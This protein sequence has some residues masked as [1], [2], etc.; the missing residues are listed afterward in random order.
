MIII[1]V[2]TEMTRLSKQISYILRHDPASVNISLDA[3]GS[4]TV[5]K[6][7]EA[8]N[9][10]VEDIETIARNDDKGRFVIFDGKIKAAQGHSFHVEHNMKEVLNPGYVFHGTSREAFMKIM[11][12]EKIEARSRTFVHLSKEKETA[13]KVALRHSKDIVLLVVD[14]KALVISG[15]KVFESDNG[16]ILTEVVPIEFIVDVISE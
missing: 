2:M 1:I 11:E 9:V 4:V 7:S 3:K 6:L 14:A 5:K 16:V 12:S 15:K 13:R 10:T 8:L